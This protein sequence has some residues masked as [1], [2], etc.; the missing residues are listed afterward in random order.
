M[1]QGR[2]SPDCWTRLWQQIEA[3]SSVINTY[4]ATPQTTNN[5]RIETTAAAVGMMLY[6]EAKKYLL[7]SG[8]TPDALEKMPVSEVLGRYFVRSFDEARDELFK[9]TNLPLPISKK[10]TDAADRMLS[11]KVAV[12]TG[13]YLAAIILPAIGNVR[14]VIARQDRQI[15]ALAI[16]EAL[17]VYA[18]ANGK[19]PAHLTDLTLPVPKDPT[20]LEAFQYELRDGKAI[21]SSLGPSANDKGGTMQIEIT[22]RK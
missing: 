10:G 21:L 17:R 12:G 11:R 13:N 2:F 4:S 7:A 8:M 5:A 3:L 18:A 19:L 15:A 1:R 22:L 16:V 20:T 14:V 6:P 9:W